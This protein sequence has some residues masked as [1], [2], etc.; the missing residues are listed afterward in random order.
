MI[1]PTSY[2]E[3]ST[4]PCMTLDERIAVIPGMQI[5]ALTVQS[6][7]ELLAEVRDRPEARHHYELLLEYRRQCCTVGGFHRFGA[8][9]GQRRDTPNGVIG[10]IDTG[11]HRTCEFC[12]AIENEAERVDTTEYLRRRY[13]PSMTERDAARARAATEM[14]KG[15]APPK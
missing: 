4:T 9:V 11:R 3:I 13:G 7:E 6:I 15:I 5:R 12:S 14:G 2:I 1:F 8:W 10:L